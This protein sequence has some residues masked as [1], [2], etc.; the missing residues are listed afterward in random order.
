MVNPFR[1]KYTIMH[2]LAVPTKG[3]KI[4]VTNMSSFTICTV[5][6]VTTDTRVNTCQDQSTLV[7]LKNSLKPSQQMEELLASNHF[8][9]DNSDNPAQGLAPSQAH[10]RDELANTATQL[11]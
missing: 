9:N 1:L 3:K 8:R 2:T 11:K 6:K 10:V 4:T 7:P 5:A